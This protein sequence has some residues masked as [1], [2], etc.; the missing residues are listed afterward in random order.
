MRLARKSVQSEIKNMKAT[1][2][3]KNGQRSILIVG[4]LEYIENSLITH[5]SVAYI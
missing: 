3:F 1:Q 4:E 5:N 2:H